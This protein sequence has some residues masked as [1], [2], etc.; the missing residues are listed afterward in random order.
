MK[1]SSLYANKTSFKRIDFND[2]VNIIIGRINNP[3]NRKANTHNLGKSLIVKLVD[4]LLLKDN[5]GDDFFLKKSDKFK[6]YVFFLEIK[7]NDG[8]FVTIK[9]TVEKASRISIKV[10]DKSRQNLVDE[11][12]WDYENI[13]IKETKNAPKAIDIM[14]SLLN[15]DILNDEKYR[16]IMTYFMREQG[17]YKNPFLLGKFTKGKDSAWKPM[18]F[19]LL[20]Y[21]GKL[22]QE[23][24]DVTDEIK[25]LESEIEEIEKYSK[26]KDGD[27]D[28]QQNIKKLC[29]D[30]VKE[31][32]LRAKNFDFYLSDANISK[33]L[34]EEI[35]NKVAELNTKLFKAK[36]D[37]ARIVEE[38]SMNIAYDYDSV[39]ALFQEVQL[40][41]PDALKKSFDELV[42]F[43][44]KITIERQVKLSELQKRKSTEAAQFDEQL[45]ELNRQRVSALKKLQEVETFQ[46][47]NDAQSGI[48]AWRRRIFEADQKIEAIQELRKKQAA[49]S[50][51]R[52]K[53]YRLRES[54]AVLIEK[55]T[56][57]ATE[58]RDLFTKYVKKIIE[59]T[60]TLG[61]ELPKSKDSGNINFAFIILGD[62][63]KETQAGDGYTHKKEICASMD[64]AILKGYSQKSFFRFVIHDGCLDGDDPRFAT[65]YLELIEELG[66][67]GL[68]CIVTMIDSV[69][70][71]KPDGSKYDVNDSEVVLELND[72]PDGSGKLFGFNF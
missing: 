7:L 61:L 40:I 6:D 4:F 52:T 45:H 54:V 50:A 67:S 63:G 31:L 39:F 65:G 46:K 19:E 1:L 53:F 55:A 8:R 27:I 51:E 66:R 28:A 38:L 16:N 15:F 22:L 25:K 26:V 64:L 70:P 11:A 49:L 21:N 24:F 56:E 36:S 68:Q 41:F 30:K 72:N 59:Q 34:I 57:K 37:L 35:E 10:H 29:E 14:Q 23:I 9:R 69:V 3:E 5:I 48:D 44:K 43:N 12:N 60:A 33:E 18:L 13:P 20:G 62:D 32:E 42:E 17:D 47:F 71:T 2:G 58:I